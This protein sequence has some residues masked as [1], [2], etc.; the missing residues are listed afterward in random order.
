MSLYPTTKS[1]LLEPR[2]VTGIALDLANDAT[3][4]VVDKLPRLN[5]LGARFSSAAGRFTGTIR[6]AAEDA[7]FLQAG[8][9]DDYSIGWGQDLPMFE[10]AEQTTINYH[11]QK[12]GLRGSLPR[13]IKAVAAAE[14]IKA[15][16]IFEMPIIDRIKTLADKQVLDVLGDSSTAWS[17]RT[18]A[19][20]NAWDTASGDPMKDIFGVAMK[21]CVP[22]CSPDTCVLA[23]D[24]AMALM[25]NAKFLA[26]RP[27]QIDRN[28]A[29]IE[30]IESV[31]TGVL[32]L[33]VIV[34]RAMYNSSKT[35]ATTT[36]APVF[37]AKCW[38]GRLGT[39]TGADLF[40]LG[41]QVGNDFAAHNLACALIVPEDLRVESWYD[42]D[43]QCD[44]FSTT[45]HQA[46]VQCQAKCG[47]LLTGCNS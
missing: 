4:Y 15:Y 6:M 34:S 33:R 21:A 29:K 22:Y 39:G 8:K 14:Q 44:M 28:I 11:A 18:S 32:G 3:G 17:G 36:L 40:G 35:K 26:A 10:G 2:V 1:I 27:Q 38:V 13:E 5:E 9:E 31:L 23:Y 30:D 45:K 41:M 25:S 19:C 37:S 46:F 43:R 20:A 7:H 12:F 42:Y 16:R 47:Y 24:A